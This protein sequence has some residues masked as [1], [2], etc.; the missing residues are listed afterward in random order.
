MST[1][2]ARRELEEFFGREN[3]IADGHES[4]VSP[5]GRYRLD[6]D[7]YRVS[8]QHGY[9]SRGIVWRVEDDTVIADVKRN[10]D[11]WH[12]W[13]AQHPSGN[14]YLLC[15]EDY[16]GYT[17]INLDR[18]V[19]A[20]YLPPEASEGNGFCWAAAYASPDGGML[21]VEGCYWACPYE[22]VFYDF[23]NPTV[24]PL[25][26]L[27]RIWPLKR[28]MGWES[29]DTFRV[30]CSYQTRKSDGISFDTLSRQEQEEL[31]QQ[32]SLIGERE[33]E[34][35]WMLRTPKHHQ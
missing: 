28:V 18:G 27:H 6:I 8:P 1:S 10:Y 15:G 20:N 21:A 13:V 2:Q 34:V 3:L 5:S 30:V 14:E 16:Q 22:I 31:L 35:V 25:P 9:Y 23:T 17:V 7:E 26:E 11:F 4:A 19:V 29:G 24:L 32:P 12:A 33:A